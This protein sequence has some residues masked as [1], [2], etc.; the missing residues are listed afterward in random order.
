MASV[1]FVRRDVKPVT[2]EGVLGV[3][4]RSVVSGETM[5]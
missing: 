3:Q 1:L 4:I 5:K 2:E